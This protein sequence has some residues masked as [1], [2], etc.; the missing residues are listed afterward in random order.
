MNL[1]GR[2]V[3]GSIVLLAGAMAIVVGATEVSLRHDMEASLASSL[4]AEARIVAS[5]LPADSTEW[6][7]AVRR[8]AGSGGH[9]ITLIDTTGRVR[10]DNEVPDATLPFVENHR[11]RPEVE[12]ALAGKEG[13]AERRSVT[14]AEDLLYVAVRGGPGVV[15]VAAPYAPVQ[16]TLDRARRAVLWAALLALLAGSVAA[17]IAS[18]SITGPLHRITVAARAIASGHQPVLPVT[19]IPDVATL[20][21]ALRDMHEQLTARFDALRREQARIAAVVESMVEGLIA[22]DA[23][24][25]VVLANTAARRLLGYPVDAVLPAIDE[26]FRAKPAREV[27]AEVRAGGSVTGRELDLEGRTIVASARPLPQ[28]GA[29]LVLHD[30]TE[31]R[32]LQVMRRDFVAN[33]SHELKTP[34]TSISGYAETLIA[35]RPGPEVAGR[36][37]QIILDNARRM[38]RL[39]DGLLDLSRVESGRWRPVPERLDVASLAREVWDGLGDRIVERGATLALELA[40]E[41][42]SIVTDA[43]ALRQVL[44]NFLDNALRYSPAGSPVTVATSR[45][46]HGIV[47]SVRDRGP[48]IPAEHLP[49]IFERFYRADPSRSR[50][51]GGTGLGLAIVKHLVE[52]QGGRVWAESRIGE[53][54]TVSAWLPDL[55]AGGDGPGPR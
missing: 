35:D 22:A 12:A 51:E 42:E 38:Q 40:P 14:V 26:I 23:R 5:A 28:G 48:G 55:A 25:T 19:G 24:G 39:V 45:Q 47:V 3:T 43:D 37:L 31:V 4:R 41:A 10:A 44:T 13:L 9:R 36:F 18:R 20:V 7:R 34:L 8:L 11:T 33:V 53:G 46:D 52:A 6:G 16:D 29:V 15:R 32:R 54:A 17:L 49:R 30:L 21:L 27:V 50:D 1:S 2:V